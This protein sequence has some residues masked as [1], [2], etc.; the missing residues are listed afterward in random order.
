M[1]ESA[2]LSS[3]E[4]LLVILEALTGQEFTPMRVA[5]I[6]AITGLPTATIDNKLKTLV[7]YKWVE[8][9]GEGYHLGEFLITAATRHQVAT[10]RAM[11]EIM[12]KHKRLTKRGD[13]A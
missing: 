10:T 7:E 3:D 12:E 2:K 13:Y 11:H 6:A 1:S 4:K 8:K 9:S 5:E